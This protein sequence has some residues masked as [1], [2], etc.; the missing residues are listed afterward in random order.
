MFKKIKDVL[1]NMFITQVS[2]GKI[3]EI[4]FKG[5]RIKVLKELEDFLNKSN[6]YLDEK[7]TQQDSKIYKYKNKYVF[8]N[9]VPFKDIYI[10]KAK[11]LNEWTYFAMLENIRDLS[12]IN[13]K[14]HSSNLVIVLVNE[15]NDVFERYL[16]EFAYQYGDSLRNITYLSVIGVVFNDQKIYL[17]AIND[18]TDVSYLGN[19]FQTIIFSKIKNYRN[20]K[21]REIMKKSE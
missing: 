7:Y 19:Y 4:E 1:K 17:G 6:I 18:D 16:L 15:Y 5:S 10:V 12:E 13:K 11:T 8:Y 14:T 3:E 20:E 2:F 9:D 21:R